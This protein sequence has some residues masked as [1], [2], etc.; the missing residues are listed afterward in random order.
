MTYRILLNYSLSLFCVS[1]FITADCYGS[2][3]GA[4]PGPIEEVS[5]R[6]PYLSSEISPDS[7]PGAISVIDMEQLKQS[8]IGSLADVLR[9]TPGVW[10][11]S[12]AG[13][14][15][16]F[17]SSRGSNLDATDFDH[18]GIRLM[19]D[20]LPVT[21]ADGNNHN[22]IIDPLASHSAT[23]AKGAN[24]SV[25]GV[26]NLG[27]AINFVS[28]TG[29]ARPGGELRL[30]GGD[31]GLKSAR[32]SYG[33]DTGYSDAFITLEKKAWDGY[34]QHNEQDRHG[35]YA[36][37]GWELS[38]RISN[39]LYVSYVKDDQELP[40][41]LSLADIEED[42]DQ[43]SDNAIGGN[44]QLNVETLRIADKA[45]F[46]MAENQLLEFGLSYEEQDQFHPIVDKILVDFDGTGPLPPTEVFSLLIDTDHEDLAFMTRYVHTF[47]NHE[48]IL[49]LNVGDNQATGGNFRNDNGQKNGQSSIVDNDAQTLEFFVS[50]KFAASS[51]LDLIFGLLAVSADRRTKIED[52]DSGLT[53][54]TD[55][56]YSRIN[57]RFGAL[58]AL[59]DNAMLYGN[60]SGL[61]EAPT[62][63]ELEDDA[64]G[65]GN[66]LEDMHGTVLE[67]GTRG[68]LDCGRYCAVSWDSA[69]FYAQVQDEIL[70][71]ES[72]DVPGTNLV[73]NVDD[74]IH[75]GLEASLA[76]IVSLSESNF[77][78]L[79]PVLSYTLNR[80]QFDG[81]EDFGNND[82]PGAPEY[83]LRG[84]VIYRNQA[85][86]YFGPTFEMVGKRQVDFANT[87]KVG[88][89][90]LLGLRAGWES[91]TLKFFFDL[92]N[93]LDESYISVHTVR[94]RF[95]ENSQIFYPGA[96]LSAY[97][98]VIFNF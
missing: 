68:Q 50:D 24:A 11:A 29:T 80:F 62:L 40:G 75:A 42:P 84:E 66:P 59:G 81:D 43:A 2:S 17:F 15:N 30:S 34:R 12:Y 92:Q 89:Y 85:G 22:R 21:A 71:V 91:D 3:E 20:G 72:P 70:A 7:V 55:E 6:A 33:V 36:N 19:Q 65:L 64:G 27:G 93:L 46:Q 45:V 49:G 77:H 57:P 60:I 38:E 37:I 16:V 69:V 25:Y 88:S 5:I 95:E 26:S 51:R 1:L 56:T 47:G 96:P 82:L 32:V 86:Y 79:E 23:V 76:A 67:I 9:L 41:A 97:G 18:N 39:R 98:G 14:E 87:A 90:S 61:F 78:Q 31:H 4:D 58:F 44:Y 53:T 48:F 10:A 28:P 35:L 54:I 73:T 63:Y 74:T 83:V 94:T 13:N 8:N 52:L